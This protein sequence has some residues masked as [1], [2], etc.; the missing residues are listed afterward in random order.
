MATIE[1]I[2]KEL[3]DLGVQDTIEIRLTRIENQMEKLFYV[4]NL[5]HT[6]DIKVEQLFIK[7]TEFLYEIK[8]V[9]KRNK[10]R[11]EL[12]EQLEVM[13]LKTHD[14]LVKVRERLAEIEKQKI[15]E[16][17]KQEVRLELIQ[18]MTNNV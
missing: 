5:K 2:Q 12:T 17:L 8:E 11:A 10:R 15:R 3:Y 18:E 13:K 9:K 6:Q 16:K 1:F 4:A 14:R 7:F